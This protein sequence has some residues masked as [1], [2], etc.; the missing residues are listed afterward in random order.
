MQYEIP[1]HLATHTKMNMVHN[2]NPSGAKRHQ[3]FK[4][5]LNGI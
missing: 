5:K 2:Y 1:R 4:M 3:F